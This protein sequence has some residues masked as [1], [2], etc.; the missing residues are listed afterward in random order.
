MTM[1]KTKDIN[2][3]MF[4]KALRCYTIAPLALAISTAL[5]FTG[6][7]DKTDE[8]VTLYQNAEQ[9]IQKNPSMVNECTESYQQAIKEAEKTA[10]KYASREACIEEFSEKAC[11]ASPQSDNVTNSHVNQ[12]NSSW[13][14][15]MAGYMFGRLSSGIFSN[16]PLFSGTA[17]KGNFVDASGRKVAG[18]SSMGRSVNVNKDVFRPKPATTTTTTRGGFGRTVAK[19]SSATTVAS[20]RSSSSTHRSFGG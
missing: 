1:K 12:S 14:P 17:T 2:H 3:S 19:A 11:I 15:L 4:R 10:P 13:M 6:C 5:F 8:T 16:T 7:Q 18:A 20:S 9:C